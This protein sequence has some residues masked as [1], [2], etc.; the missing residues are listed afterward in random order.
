MGFPFLFRLFLFFFFDFVFLIHFLILLYKI[1]AKL[2]RRTIMGTYY[3]KLLY[4]VIP[5]ADKE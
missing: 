1:F 4:I 2:S 5:M 3:G